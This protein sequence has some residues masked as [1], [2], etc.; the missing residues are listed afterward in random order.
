MLC[1]KCGKNPAT[2]M[3]TQ[4]L[5]GQKSSINI[6]SACAGKE[7]IFDNFGSL[8]SFNHIGQSAAVCSVCKTSLSEFNRS[9]RAGCGNCYTAFRQHADAMLRKIHGTSQHQT[10]NTPV[11]EEVQKEPA[12][13]E[14]S[15][16]EILKEKMAEA[17][18]T[19]NFEEAAKLR[20][21]IKNLG[22]DGE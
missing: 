20:D 15:K 10:D 18:Q 5:N 8:L 12:E 16:L 7:S 2:V 3:Y 22:K 9:G 17:I 6:C 11:Q 19:E 4:I 14:K 13:K 1:E 21:E